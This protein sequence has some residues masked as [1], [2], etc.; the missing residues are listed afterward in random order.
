MIDN[1]DTIRQQI[2]S[3]GYCVVPNVIDPATVDR[4]SN[5]LH[6]LLAAERVLPRNRFWRWGGCRGRG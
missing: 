6:D 2:D 5:A 1:Y 3:K 4:A